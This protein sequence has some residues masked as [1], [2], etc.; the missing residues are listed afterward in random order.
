MLTAKIEYIIQT[1]E[2]NGDFVGTYNVEAVLK[3][4]DNSKS[5]H[6]IFIPKTNSLPKSGD[7]IELE[8]SDKFRKNLRFKACKQTLQTSKAV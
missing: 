5:T 1:E 8:L 6:W 7:S 2:G 3:F 4:A